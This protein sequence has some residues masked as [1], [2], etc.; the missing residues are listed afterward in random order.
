MLIGTDKQFQVI[1]NV[2]SND[3]NDV[4]VCKDISNENI[5]NYFTLIKIYNSD[6]IKG[7]LE[8]IYDDNKNCIL[9][10]DLFRDVFI[11]VDNLNILFNY[12]IPN[13]IF[14]YLDA[15]MIDDY[16][17]HTIIKNFIYQC[18]ALDTCFPILDLFL[19]EKN[20]NLDQN[21]NV[22]FNGFLDFANFDKNANEKKCARKCSDIINRIL[23]SNE[24]LTRKSSV[25]SISL[26]LKKRHNKNYNKII[27]IYNDFKLKENKYNANHTFSLETLKSYLF[28]IISDKLTSFFTSTALIIILVAL[29]IFISNLFNMDLPFFKYNGMNVI[30]NVD[31]SKK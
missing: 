24:I 23:L 31:M 14:S 5:H 10:N 13:V 1:R 29:I 21:L 11:D 3:I 27:D 8:V 4:F 19:D 12:S 7:I 25:K 2:I 16:S 15:Y 20:I 30:G 26:F 9:P 22:F 18:L 6:V 17:Q 28:N